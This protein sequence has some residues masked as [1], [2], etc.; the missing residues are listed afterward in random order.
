[1]NMTRK[2]LMIWAVVLLA[3]SAIVAGQN[4]S[5]ESQMSSDYGG[6]WKADGWGNMQPAEC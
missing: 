3:A 4:H 5:N 6:C 1:M 2:A